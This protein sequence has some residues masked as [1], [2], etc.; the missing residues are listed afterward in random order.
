M[1]PE[2]VK[3]VFDPIL[4]RPAWQV[5]KGH[6]S[7]LTFEFGSPSLTVR[8]P[9]A[10]NPEISERLNESR[11]R[12]LVT[13]R[14]EWHLWI[15]CCHWEILKME[16]FLSHNES[17]DAVIEKAASFLDGQTLE[18]V[19]VLPDCSTVFRFDLGGIL[20]TRPWDEEEVSEQ[21]M[22]YEPSGM[23]FEINSDSTYSHFPGS[24]PPDEL[25]TFP[26]FP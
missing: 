25:E 18:S 24:T 17:P 9:R 26:L 20:R 16:K 7:F 8:E 15:Y 19:S 2:K 22:L 6:G 23:V 5:K 1:T 13:I 11:G 10:F 4:G 21:W 3:K 12:R 14:G